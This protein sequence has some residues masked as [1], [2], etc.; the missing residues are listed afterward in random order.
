MFFLRLL[1]RLPL[2]VLYAFSDFLFVTSFYLVRYRR[3]MVQKNLKNA[4]PE[5]SP[6]ER[7]KIEVDF[8]KN[9]CDYAVEMLKL[10]TISKEELSRRMVFTNP[11]V[12]E[13]YRAKNQ[14]I[15]FLASHQFNWEWLLASASICFPMAIE[16]V[17][18]PVSNKFF[19]DFSIMSRSRFGAHPI[20][21]D[22][23]AR[24]LVKRKNKLRG[25]ASV[26]DQYPGYSHDKKYI[27]KFL[28]QETVF[29]YGT[30]TL[31]QLTQFPVLYYPIR[32]VK[33]GYYEASPIIVGTPP[34]EKTSEVIL[35]NYIREVEKN[36]CENP[37]GWLWSHNRWKKRHLN[38]MHSVQNQ[39]NI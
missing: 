28:N 38:Q 32:R 17:Y 29:F 33:R 22:E 20:K 24:E 19:N 25:I 5:K 11:E 18:Q 8:Y 13:G 30:N 3:K 35:D 39:A 31:A 9:L 15:F 16:F 34:Y 2:P 6:A 12:L 10:L 27:T 23:V 37:S 7:R 26:A 4:F 14:S 1:S 21:R 36:I